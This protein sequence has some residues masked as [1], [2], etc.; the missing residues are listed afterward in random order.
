MMQPDGPIIRDFLA[1]A[2]RSERESWPD[3]WSDPAAI[4]AVGDAAIFHGVAGLLVDS[5]ALADWP[6]S[7]A[8]RLR[9]QARAQAMWELRH[10]QL[11]AQLLPALADQGIPA[12]LL[13]GSAIAYDLYDRPAA[14][15]RGDTDLLVQR[16]SLGKARAVLQALGFR[17]YELH[18]GLDDELAQQ[19]IW[20]MSGDGGSSHGIDLHWEVLNAQSLKHVLPADECLASTRA[21]S[22]LSVAA[23]TLDRPRF[24]LHTCVHRAMHRIAPYFTDGKP[25]YD[26]GRLIWSWD[27]K[28]LAQA[29]V[30]DEWPGFGRLAADKGVADACLSGLQAAVDDFG[31]PV[32]PHVLA[33]LKAAGGGG[34]LRG[35]ALQRAWRDLRSVSGSGAKWRY[36]RGRLL[37][38]PGF[39]RAKYPTM[40]R[41]PLIVL[42]ARRLAESLRR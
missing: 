14:R 16:A 13:K 28:L 29:M 20:T 3:G 35:N 38:A 1:A 42:Y 39:M 32:P 15:S 2:L 41:A 19:E 4:D 40:A 33:G 37:P 5:A 27:I 23:R 34:Y 7:L 11:L 21:L 30:G 10:R 36:L 31:A 6:A 26:E 22:S 9:D 24:L 25:H 17:Q 12:L 18:D 8:E